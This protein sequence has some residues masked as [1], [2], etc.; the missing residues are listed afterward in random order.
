VTGAGDTYFVAFRAPIGF[1]VGLPEE[2]RNTVEVREEWMRYPALQL[3]T[4]PTCQRVVSC[5]PSLPT[6][7]YPPCSCCIWMQHCILKQ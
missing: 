2:A 1:D 4:Q 6:L 5:Q 7:R 3:A